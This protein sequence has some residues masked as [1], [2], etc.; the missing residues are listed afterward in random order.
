[1]AV[2]SD[3]VLAP[4]AEAAGLDPIALGRLT[5]AVRRDIDAGLHFGAT[6]LVARAGVV[7]YHEPIGMVDPAVERS[8]SREDLYFLASATKSITAVAVLQMIDRGLL[9]LVR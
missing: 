6:V 1:M 8:S 7:G 5:A 3:D 2:L 9:S 4:D